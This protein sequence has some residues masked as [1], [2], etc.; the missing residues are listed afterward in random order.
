MDKIGLYIALILSIALP[1]IILSTLAPIVLAQSQTYTYRLDSSGVATVTVIATNLSGLYTYQLR[2]DKGVI[3]ET[4]SVVN[5]S[6]GDP[7]PINLTGNLLTI[8]LMNITSSV[9]ITYTAVVG[10][11]TTEGYV[12]AIVSPQGPSNIVLP[13]GAALLYF[14]G[15]PS[16]AM[17][18]SVI[19]LT[20]S[21]AGTYEVK[22]LPPP[23]STTTTTAKPVTTT[24]TTSTTSATVTSTT[25]TTTAP[26]KTS[27]TVTK[28]TATTSKT[29]TVPT[30]TSIRTTSPVTTAPLTKT[31]VTTSK[32]LPTTITTK[33]STTTKAV[34]HI[35][36]TSTKPTTTSSLSVTSKTAT[37]LTTTATTVKTIASPVTSKS[38]TTAPKPS[39]PTI[40]TGLIAG[41]VAAIVVASIIT[42]LIRR[43]GTRSTQAASVPMEVVKEELDERDA[44]IL[45]AL[46]EESMNISALAKKLGLSKS[47]VWRRANK[48]SRLGLITKIEE[49]GKVILKITD[50]GI[51]AL[52]ELFKGG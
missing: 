46:K 24:I 10:N 33:T 36:T 43:R 2:L 15:S 26:T 42:S 12:D 27:I 40:P 45:K 49:G 44:E 16:I 23:P 32:A 3:P 11:L 13:N 17:K 35:V 30:T 21:T 48:L 14:N 5:A 7:V 1:L 8:Y 51:R 6:T 52:E 28:T 9:I 19:V 38:V 34:T 37:K 4:V 41:V 18:G 25:T 47:V 50:E 22:Y 31:T 29:T 20:Y 39:G